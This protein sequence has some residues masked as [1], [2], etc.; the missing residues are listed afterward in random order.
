M[1]PDL[2]V[3]PLVLESTDGR[4]QVWTARPGLVL[5]RVDGRMVMDHARAIM[6]AVDAQ[7]R[8][9]P[10]RTTVVHDWTGIESYEVAVHARMSAW[11]VS[12]IRSFE[13]VIIGVTSPLVALAVRTV[14]IAVGNRFE[15]LD[16][17]EGVL[18][19]ATAELAR[20]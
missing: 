1:V 19:A 16:S 9:R 6:E 7:L 15:L 4:A 10:G 12:T 18:A 13:R 5:T 11:A 3:T 17:R 8:A 20:R 14:N 2:D